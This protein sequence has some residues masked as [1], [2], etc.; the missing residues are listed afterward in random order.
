MRHLLHNENITDVNYNDGDHGSGS[1]GGCEDSD[2]DDDFDGSG[3]K[4]ID[5]IYNVAWYGQEGMT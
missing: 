2:D 3:L 4:I 1:H 5:I